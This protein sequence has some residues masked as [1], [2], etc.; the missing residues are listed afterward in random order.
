MGT[1]NLK[2]LRGSVL[3]ELVNHT[4]EK[5]KEQGLALIQKIPTSIKP[6]RFD[7]TTRQITLAYFDQKSTV[8]YIGA[9][10]GIPVCFDAKE[11]CTDN[12]PLQNIHAHQVEFMKDFEKQQGIA[13]LILYFSHRDEIY[14]MPFQEMYAF[15]ERG[16]NG[17]R[18]HFKYSELSPR[19]FLQ[20]TGSIMV[21]FLEGI[22]KDLE[23]R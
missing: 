23:S 6:V 10:Q 11:C 12:F 7:K 22:Q 5:Y 20:R 18:K 9:V 15:W 2:G 8:D 16:Q 17:G 19:W 13:F 3:E 14:Y 1:W 21:P 4:N